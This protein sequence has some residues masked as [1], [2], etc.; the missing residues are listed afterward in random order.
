[1]I[2]KA[3]VV[4]IPY[5]GGSSYMYN[6]MSREL[7]GRK[8]I[9][10]AIDLPGKGSRIDEIP[11]SDFHDALSDTV[12]TL[13]ELGNYSSNYIFGYSMGALLAYE[14]VRYIYATSKLLPPHLFLAACDPPAVYVKQSPVP[15]DKDNE[16]IEYLIKGGGIT[17]DLAD[18]Q[19][20]KDFFL[21]IVRNDHKI[22]DTYKYNAEN[23]QIPMKATILY[24]DDETD[25][26]EWSK[27]FNACSFYHF[28]GG[29]FFIHQDLRRICQIINHTLDE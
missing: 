24:S 23:I 1:M 6:D 15:W 20:F 13:L 19:D 27:C 26:A 9:I 16:F 25:I 21:P 3:T 5:A 22:L 4:C 7:A 11:C 2:S 10:R 8:A 12:K 18:D 29:H 14:A 28:G 17:R